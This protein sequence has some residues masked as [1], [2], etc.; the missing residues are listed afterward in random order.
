MGYREINASSKKRDNPVFIV[1]W[2]VLCLCM[3]CVYSVYD[4]CIMFMYEVYVGCS[5]FEH[6]LDNQFVGFFEHNIRDDIISLIIGINRR[7]CIDD[8]VGI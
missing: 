1:F 6:V 7:I 4:V 2:C 3:M 5:R 8:S